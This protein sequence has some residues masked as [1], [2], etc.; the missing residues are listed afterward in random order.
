MLTDKQHREQHPVK[1]E[2]NINGYGGTFEV[3]GWDLHTRKVKVKLGT[4]FVWIESERVT[5]LN[6]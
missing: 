4:D 2:C 5:L 1:Q 6:Q 3:W